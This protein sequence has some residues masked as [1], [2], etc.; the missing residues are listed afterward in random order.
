[1]ALAGCLGPCSAWPEGAGPGTWD[2]ATEPYECL[3]DLHVSTSGADGNPGTESAP[4][5][6][7]GHALASALEAGDCIILE[8]GTYVE[9]VHWT[10][11]GGTVDSSSG[12]VVLQ[13]RNR[14]GAKVR[15]PAGAYS[16]L[17]IRSSFVIVDGLDVVGGDGHAIDIEAS[18]HVKVLNTLAHDSGGSGISA[19]KGEFFLFEGNV[20]YNNTSTNGYQG[21]GIS[22]YWAR[23]I[24]GDDDF[25]GFRNIVRGNISFGNVEGPSIP[26]PHTDGNGIIIDDFRHT[27]TTGVPPYPYPT[28]IESNLAYANGGKGIQVTWSDHVTI[29]NNTAHGNNRDNLNPGTWRGELSN[30]QSSFNTWVNNIAVADAGLNPNNT[31]LD[32]VS[33]DGYLNTDVAWVANLGYNRSPLGAVVRTDGGNPPPGPEGG[34]LLGA[35]PRFLA[36]G[37]DRAADF[38]LLA[39]SPAVDAG[40]DIFGLPPS[41]LDGQARTAGSK[42]DLGAYEHRP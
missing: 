11:N 3:R 15:P 27:Q 38:R 6:T 26:T 28:L 20:T 22:I 12:Y 8:D 16:T 19:W 40:T 13:A 21:S 29:R 25:T 4:W 37:D 7:I 23:A 2:R 5:R 34:N 32:N 42:V 30:A 35:D 14:H 10:D 33:Y 39:V 41:D 17:T 24:S 18:H 1:M 9:A 36:P 31:A